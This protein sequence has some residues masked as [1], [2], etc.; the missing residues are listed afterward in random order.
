MCCR[1]RM[2]I[3]PRWDGARRVFTDQADVAYLIQNAKRRDV[4]GESHE[5][6]AASYQQMLGRRAFFLHIDYSVG[7]GEGARV[8]ARM[9]F[10]R[11]PSLYLYSAV[12]GLYSAVEG[13]SLGARSTGR[14]SLLP[15]QCGR[16]S[17]LGPERLDF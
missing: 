16:R 11:K 1:S 17:T 7:G 4:L 8:G 15:L 5:G 9:D 14:P 3:D 2:A 10:R 6:R 12:E 13:S